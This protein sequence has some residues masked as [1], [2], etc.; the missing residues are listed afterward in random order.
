MNILSSF[1]HFI[2][3]F[4]FYTFYIDSIAQCPT[5]ACIPSGSINTTV[6]LGITNFTLNTINNTTTDRSGS[7]V[8]NNYACALSTTLFTGNTYNFSIS[9]NGLSNENVK[10]WIDINN[11]GFFNTSTETFF[12]ATVSAPGGILNSTITMPVI[13]VKNIPLRLRIASDGNGFPQPEPCVNP[14]LG[15]VEDYSIIL[16]DSPN[17]PPVANFEANKTIVCNGVVE[18]KDLSGNSPTSWFWD[19]GDGQTSIEQNPVHTYDTSGNFSVKLV[20]TNEWGSDSLTQVN[21]I[22]NSNDGPL[23]AI[24]TPDTAQNVGFGANAGIYNV[25]LNTINHSSGGDIEGYQDYSCTQQTTLFEATPY[26]I[27]VTTGDNFEENVKIWVDLNNDGTFQISEELFLS[28]NIVGTH[29]GTITIPNGTV[30]NT[31]LRMRVSADYNGSPMP[32]ACST[33]EY[34]QVEDYGVTIIENFN[35]PVAD[36]EATKLISCDGFFAFKDRSINGATSWLWNFGDGTTS[37]SKNPN[38]I[39]LNTGV[40]TVKLVVSNANGTDSITKINYVEYQDTVPVSACTPITNGY[41]CGYGITNFALNTI[42][43]S[44]SN[45]IAGYEDFSCELRTTLVEGQSY[46][47]SIT[48]NPNLNETTRVWI[49]YNNDGVFTDSSEIIFEAFDTKNPSGNVIISSNV[50]YDT[51]LRLRV[52]S[53]YAASSFTSCF[54]IIHGQAEDYTVIIKENQTPPISNFYANT[55]VTC[56]GEIIFFNESLNSPDSY[57][58]DFGDGNTSTVKNPVHTYL[59][60]GIYT[61][62]LY[63]FNESGSDT[64]TI[65][66]YIRFNDS[67]IQSC[68]PTTISYC[69]NTGI[70]R[71]IL[72]EI[73]NISSD[74][75]IPYEDFSCI[76]V[77]TLQAGKKHPVNITT[78]NT[79]TEHVIMWI[80]LN[81]DGF[82]D[83]DTEKVFANTNF[84]NHIG[85]IDIPRDAIYDTTLRLRVTSERSSSP[86]PSACSNLFNGQH[87]DYGIILTPPDSL[88]FISEN[89]YANIN[90]YPNPASNFITI[91]TDD[92]HAIYSISIINALGKEV[93]TS[94]YNSSKINISH[95]SSGIYVVTLK[96]SNAIITKKLI[97]NEK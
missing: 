1:K 91:K 3:L 84:R 96:T 49:D 58:W 48:T 61:V 85:E 20:A 42:N 45:A 52:I 50:V 9:T 87:E 60:P 14:R 89:L 23:L 39:Y 46:P 64:L 5:T 6:D 34:S 17:A 38:K 65:A 54:N 71:F 83:N 47:I 74:A 24:C 13:A 78:G 25:I 97:I 67:P 92:N 66:D 77:T 2:V 8:Y 76:E 31:I 53:D 7:A 81:N 90:I 44:S 19:F 62:T 57:L 79:I 12:S 43:K 26:A 30:K 80:D 56:D 72:N 11:D 41:C 86:I 73:D 95:L 82:F 93:Y 22:S 4:L 21:Y 27:S 10:I 35:P 28:E 36:F 68:V 63:T 88:D 15:Q 69:C 29:T 16:E 33:P 75:S 70:Q 55:T 37:I 59:T 32:T 94:K 40:Y 18:F 51:P